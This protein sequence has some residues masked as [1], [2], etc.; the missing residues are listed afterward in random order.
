M[1]S[2][3]TQRFSDRVKDYIKYRPGYT[4]EV[5]N[6]IESTCQLTPGAVIADIGSGTGIFSELLLERGYRVYGIEPN[7]PMRI[8]AEELLKGQPKFISVNGSSEQTTLPGH[9]VDLVTAATAFHW[10]RRDEAKKEFQRILKPNGWVAL[11]WNERRPD[12]DEFAQAYEALLC[13]QPDYKNVNDKYSSYDQLKSFFTEGSLRK[14][15][16]ANEQIFDAESLAGR[17]RSSSFV[18]QPDT[19]ESK[20][21]FQQLYNMFARYQKNGKVTFWY[22]TVVYT[23]KI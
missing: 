21:F 20:D 22:N 4:P 19:A 6:Y 14:A 7:D 16:F 10:F 2:D 1:S 9:S 5:L 13:S 12:A 23:G 8:A 17:A 18:P 3:P 11:L 15:S